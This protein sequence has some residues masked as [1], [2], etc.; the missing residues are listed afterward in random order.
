MS[1][2]ELGESVLVGILIALDRLWLVAAKHR[3]RC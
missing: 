3:S 2:E 1:V